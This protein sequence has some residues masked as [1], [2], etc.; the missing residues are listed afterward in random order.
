VFPEAL[1]VSVVIVGTVGVVLI[2]SVLVEVALLKLVIV[3][4]P[5]WFTIPPAL[6]V[7]PVIVPEP[8]IL[9]VP[10]F[11]KF[12]NAVVVVPTADLFIIPAFSRVVIAHEPAP[13]P[14]KY[15]VPLEL[16]VNLP[17]P[18][19]TDETVKFPLLVRVTPV[20]V[21]LVKLYNPVPPR[22]CAF[23]VKVAPPA[24]KVFTLLLVIPPLKTTR[25]TVVADVDVH[26]PPEFMVTRP[27]KVFTAVFEFIR[28]VP[29]IVV[30]PETV[31]VKPPTVSVAEEA[32]SSDKQVAAASTK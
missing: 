3:L 7:I 17:V 28:R 22:F 19:K 5:E 9:I 23:V 16:F 25:L 24:E 15:N 21:T 8:L 20:T 11:V 18:A 1:T 26:V 12:A 27:V 29:E 31:K 10:V 14:L 13:A 6:L 30:V 2:L 32:T 4:D